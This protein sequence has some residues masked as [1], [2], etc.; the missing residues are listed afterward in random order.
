MEF[1]CSSHFIVRQTQNDF[2][3]VLI[4]LLECTAHISNQ[5]LWFELNAMFSCKVGI[6]LVQ[7]RDARLT[8]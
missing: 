8:G 2:G 6:H 4:A 3:I 1:I 5:I 7:N